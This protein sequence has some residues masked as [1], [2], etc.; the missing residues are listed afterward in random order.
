MQLR[1]RRDKVHYV[2]GKYI[3]IH[4]LTK[5]DDLTIEHGTPTDVYRT[6][7]HADRLAKLELVIEKMGVHLERAITENGSLHGRI[8]LLEKKAADAV[9]KKAT[10][11]S[12]LASD[13]P[14]QSTAPLLAPTV[15]PSARYSGGGAPAMSTLPGG[16][17]AESVDATLDAH[18]YQTCTAVA[19]DD[20]FVVQ[21]S[22]RRK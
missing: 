13:R 4:R 5:A 3:D 16:V 2:C 12:R 6:L 17:T 10:Y 9:V 21:R 19:D 20:E 1:T 15:E 14:L 7:R 11:A 22:S 18:V 8:T